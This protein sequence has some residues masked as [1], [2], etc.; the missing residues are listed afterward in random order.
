VS[1]GDPKV[2]KSCSSLEISTTSLTGPLAN[3]PTTAPTFVITAGTLV[4]ASISEMFTPGLTWNAI[5]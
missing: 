1:L 5:F 4:D 3:L 2:F